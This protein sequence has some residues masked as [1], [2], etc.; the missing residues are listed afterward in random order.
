MNLFPST[1]MPLN[2]PRYLCLWMGSGKPSATAK[3]CPRPPTTLSP[4]GRAAPL[5]SQSEQG[6]HV[7]MCLMLRGGRNTA[8]A[9]RG[10][11]SPPTH[12][13]HVRPRCPT[14]LASE[15]GQHGLLRLSPKSSRTSGHGKAVSAP[16]HHPFPRAA[17]LPHYARKRAGAGW[18]SASI[19]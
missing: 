2:P 18:P 14:T 6:Q 9:S 19:P 17:T 11:A 8:T 16:T 1:V 12:P 4:C 5:R 7:R 13:L 3:P 15:Q 10:R